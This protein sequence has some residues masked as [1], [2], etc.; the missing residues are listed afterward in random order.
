MEAGQ[1]RFK[2]ADLEQAIRA[3]RAAFPEIEDDA[4]L[5]SDTLE[6][7]TGLH[8]LIGFLVDQA[9]EQRANAVCVETMI[10]S[11][12]SR[13]EVWDHRADATRALILKVMNLANQRKIVL[14]QATVSIAVGRKGVAIIDETQ[15]P[16]EAFVIEKK[17]SKK[18]I[19]DLL[20]A[21]DCPG[22]AFTN[23]SETLM[24]R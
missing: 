6:G 9:R 10:E 1:I 5:Y 3:I 23:G 18:Q 14:P 21:G 7:E 20:E 2:L 16:A 22:A 19:K 13:V 4:E 17:V 11:L 24:I 15:L 8:D 12:K